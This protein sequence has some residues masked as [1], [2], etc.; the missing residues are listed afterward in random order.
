MSGRRVRKSLCPNLKKMESDLESVDLGKGTTT[1]DQ[2]DAEWEQLQS[3]IHTSND[4]MN[5]ANS[6]LERS[7]S[8][9]NDE[10][11]PIYSN[12]E[13]QVKAKTKEADRVRKL[14][15]EMQNRFVWDLSL[16]IKESLVY[17]K[18][19]IRGAEE[20]ISRV[21]ID[22]IVNDLQDNPVSP[23]EWQEWITQKFLQAE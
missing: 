10:N 11:L 3:R 13:L 14:A 9:E 21:G 7:I 16:A 8:F 1:S 15:I 19:H 20:K 4:I 6:S 5:Y 18:R 23:E 2:S 12:M 22:Q 17:H